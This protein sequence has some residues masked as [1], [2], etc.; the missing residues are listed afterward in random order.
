MASTSTYRPPLRKRLLTHRAVRGTLTFTISLAIRCVALLCARTNIIPEKTL[1]YFH[2]EKQAIYCF[3]HGRMLFMPLL[4]PPARPLKALISRHGD[5]A[6]IASILGWFGVGMVRG[7]SSKGAEAAT[8]QLLQAI[9]A[10][11]NI[12]ITP[13]GPRGPHQ[14]SAAGP[15]WLAAQTGL[16]LI[17]VSGTASRRKHAKS[18]DAFTL[19]LPFGRIICEAS[20]PMSITLS[21]DQSKDA[22]IEQHRL[23]LEQ[24]ITRLTHA[25]DQRAD[26]TEARHA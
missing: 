9:A 13:D 23:A 1:P 4:K 18:W 3:W 15:I 19:P 11:D 21:Q 26:N 5:G 17:A 7:S 8:R 22:Q 14:V 24:A 25:V 6:V 16:P 20:E 2:G 10:G 12:A